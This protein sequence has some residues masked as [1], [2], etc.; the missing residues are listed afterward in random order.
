MVH[1]SQSVLEM[2][3]RAIGMKPSSRVVCL[4]HRKIIFFL[5]QCFW[6]LKLIIAL[7]IFHRWA[8]QV[9]ISDIN[10]LISKAVQSIQLT[11]LEHFTKH[12]WKSPLEVN[13]N[14]YLHLKILKSSSTNKNYSFTNQIRKFLFLVFCL[15]QY[16]F[17]S[18][19]ARLWCSGSVPAE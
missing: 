18:L 15:F 16:L 12:F 6:D 2:R 13:Q 9:L 10:V 14:L 8:F 4:L 19:K 1:F 3:S 5:M 17:W 7:A 11:Q